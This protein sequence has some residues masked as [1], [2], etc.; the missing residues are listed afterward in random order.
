MQNQ[1]V[2]TLREIVELIFY[3]FTGLKL[4]NGNI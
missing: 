2:L 1:D 3:V 4:W